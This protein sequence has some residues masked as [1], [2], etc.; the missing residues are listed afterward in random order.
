MGDVGATRTG[1]VV[2][3]DGRGASVGGKGVA[4]GKLAEPRLE[5]RPGDTNGGAD[6]VKGGDVT[7]KLGCNAGTVGRDGLGKLVELDE[8]IN[9]PDDISPWKKEDD[10]A[11]VTWLLRYNPE[12][13]CVG[14]RVD[15]NIDDE[16]RSD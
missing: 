3:S 15:W 4:D 5:G 10:G 6:V 14:K 2:A 16:T 12:D 11:D 9:I 1:A 13:T 7:D 8:L